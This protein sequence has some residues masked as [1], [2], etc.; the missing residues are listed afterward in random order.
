MAIDHVYVVFSNLLYPFYFILWH[1]YHTYTPAV[2]QISTCM[3]HSV[4]LALSLRSE[5]FNNDHAQ[6]RRCQSL[7]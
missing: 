7:K 6:R 4:G 1:R 3:N 5:E 2:Y